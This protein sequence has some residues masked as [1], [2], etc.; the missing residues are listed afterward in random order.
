M[1]KW[2]N[3][4]HRGIAAVAKA[5][6]VVRQ[7]WQGEGTHPTEGEALLS[8][9]KD[10][11]PAPVFWLVGKTQSGKT[12]IIR[13]LTGASDAVIGA[14]FRPTTR[15]T[16]RYDFPTAEVPLL[17]FL[18]TRGLDEPGYDPHP[19]IAL[20]SAQ[21]H[22]VIVTVKVT[23][24]AQASVRGLLES[25]R[26]EKP[27]RPVVLCLTCLHE[28]DVH[29]PL[30]QPY[31]FRPMAASQRW[32]WPAE[33]SETLRRQLERQIQQFAG[34][35]DW[36]VPLDLTRPEDGFP[37]PDYGGPAL[38]EA[39]VQVLPQA[40]RQTLLQLESL[41][42]EL[43]DLHLQHALPV[44]IGYSMLA[45]TI[46]ALPI[47]LADLPLLLGLHVRMA[48]HVAGIYGQS[49][50][51]DHYRELAAILGTSLVTRQLTRQL[52]KLI[53][54][55]GSVVGGAV[56]FASTYALG[57]ALCYY[58]ETVCAGHVPDTATLRR[59]F[60]E[61]FTAAEAAFTR[62]APTHS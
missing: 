34:L 37:V 61:Q 33:L 27:D 62:S 31:P 32:D 50:R 53:P 13:Y 49:L 6:E 41:L 58:F 19:D 22:C 10:R 23:D 51:L 42:S 1:G 25:L 56:A 57:R 39:L 3:T 28:A 36:I 43:K 52:S 45:G 35:Y 11:L 29:A 60:Q 20:C 2:W 47:P 30:P 46:G 21:A 8:A 12:S 17:A 7:I 4:W 48:R 40:C 9:W 15:S 44:I 5:R 16:R 24:P 18:D 54:G 59:L 55:I 14:G 26:K 38:Q